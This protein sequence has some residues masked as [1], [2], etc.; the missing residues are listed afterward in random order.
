MAWTTALTAVANTMLTAGQWNASVRD[1]LLETTPGVAALSRRIFVTAGTNKIA[2]RDI[3]DSIINN[4]EDTASTSYTDLASF[5]PEVSMVTGF[6]ALVWIRCLCNNS[7][8]G[9]SRMSY[10]VSGATT[11][12]AANNKA[13]QAEGGAGAWSDAC[14]VTNLESALEPGANIFTAKYDVTSGTGT[15]DRRRVVVMG[16]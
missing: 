5:G 6:S 2:E 9:S 12:A 3:K 1:D 4:R 15:F 11:V 13:R 8:G 14:S 16:L 10:A 7:A